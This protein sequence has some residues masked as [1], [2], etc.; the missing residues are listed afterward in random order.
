VDLDMALLGLLRDVLGIRT[1]LVKSSELG[2]DGAKS[3]LILNVCK[4]AGATGLLAGFGGSRG[5]LD[6]AKFAAE[7]VKI[8][9]H[10]FA[11]PEYRQCGAAPFMPGLASIDLLFNCGPQGRDILLAE[12]ARHESCATA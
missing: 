9:W 4:A 12:P 3:D 11:H 8:E 5:Y 1:P 10:Q 6:V 2:V 7:G